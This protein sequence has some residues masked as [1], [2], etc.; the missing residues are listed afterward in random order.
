MN[1]IVEYWYFHLPNY[2]LALIQYTLMGRFVLGL[3]VDA[4]SGNYI[5]RFFVRLTDPVLRVVQMV[6]P[7]GATEGVLMVFAILWMIVLRIALFVL[8]AALDLAPKVS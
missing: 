2:V 3:F 1:P 6:T 7:L 4:E 5:W 8:L